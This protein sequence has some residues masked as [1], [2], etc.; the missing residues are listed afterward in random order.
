MSK[1]NGL[2]ILRAYTAGSCLVLEVEDNGVG[3]S[4]E[5]LERMLR[6]ENEGLYPG[7]HSIG[8]RNVNER[9]KLYYGEDYGLRFSSTEG[10]GTVA[11]ALLPLDIRLGGAKHAAGDDR[12]G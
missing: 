10:K 9:I 6:R 4:K 1:G 7:L 3:M 8:V 2:L 11:T 12:R 5:K